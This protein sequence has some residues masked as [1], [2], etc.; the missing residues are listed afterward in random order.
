MEVKDVELEHSSSFFSALY[1]PPKL[2]VRRALISALILDLRHAWP[3]WIRCF[4]KGIIWNTITISA[5]QVLG[6]STQCV[7]KRPSLYTCIIITLLTSFIKFQP[8]QPQAVLL[9]D[10]HIPL[11]FHFHFHFHFRIYIFIL[12]GYNIQGGL[13]IDDKALQLMLTWAFLAQ[14]QVYSCT[15]SFLVGVNWSFNLNILIQ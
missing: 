7:Y 9:T 6:C 5:S 3:I 1:L 14:V 13:Y 2:R 8:S 15:H 4:C 12:M 10:T 11:H